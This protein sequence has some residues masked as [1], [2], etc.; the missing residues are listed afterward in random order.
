MGN[1]I[2][3]NKKLISSLKKNSQYGNLNFASDE[4][5]KNKNIVLE[6]VKKMDSV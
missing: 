1:S 4:I 5:M 2:K 6:A 3:E